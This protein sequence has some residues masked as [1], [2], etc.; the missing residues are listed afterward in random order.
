[1]SSV[2]S[3]SLQRH[4]LFLKSG[5]RLPCLKEFSSSKETLPRRKSMLSSTPRIVRSSAVAASTVQFIGRPGR[6]FSKSA[7][8]WTDVKRAKRK[9]RKDTIFLRDG[10][11]TPVGHGGNNHEDE[12]LA[13]CY[14][15]S[16]ALAEKYRLEA[17][18]F[19]SISTGAYGFPVERA[20][21]IALNVVASYLSTAV[22]PKS[23]F[24]VC[25]SHNDYHTYL[26]SMKELTD[27][28]R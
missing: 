24:V 7:G 1:M 21:R 15:N 12:L 14:T 25:F 17:V 4:F 13:Q 2:F 27:A 23:I 6:S 10:S 3:C 8:H 28:G 26:N 9:L 19:P 11:F 22:F 5:R 18:A 20:S 16:L